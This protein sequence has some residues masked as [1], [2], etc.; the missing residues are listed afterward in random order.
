MELVEL[1]DTE[2]GEPATNTLTAEQSFCRAFVTE[3]LENYTQLHLNYQL[4]RELVD[5]H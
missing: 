3:S 4:F 5:L 1:K 2:D